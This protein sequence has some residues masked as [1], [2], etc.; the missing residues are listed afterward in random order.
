MCSGGKGPTP[1]QP[2]ERIHQDLGTHRCCGIRCQRPCWERHG[3]M[4]VLCVVGQAGGVNQICDFHQQF[5]LGGQS[6][7]AGELCD[8]ASGSVPHAPPKRLPIY[9][10]HLTLHKPH[11][12]QPMKSTSSCSGRGTQNQFAGRL[13][14]RK[15]DACLTSAYR[16]LG[17]LNQQRQK[18]NHSRRS[19]VCAN[20]WFGRL[21]S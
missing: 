21:D 8:C 15:Q 14:S 19:W 4:P 12:T 17:R 13:N 9:Y 7:I 18:S 16:W 1:R 3:E 10:E 11:L 20:C 5:E 6:F 2:H